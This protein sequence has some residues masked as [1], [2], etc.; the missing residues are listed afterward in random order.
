MNV[1][2]YAAA[3]GGTWPP[4]SQP[5]STTFALSWTNTHEPCIT[6]VASCSPRQSGDWHQPTTTHARCT[7]S[8][9]AIFYANFSLFGRSNLKQ[10]MSTKLIIKM[11]L[12]NNR[13]GDF[14]KRIKSQQSDPA[15]K[16][17]VRCE[18]Q[19]SPPA[20]PGFNNS[21]EDTIGFLIFT[22]DAANQG[23][24]FVLQ[25][26]SYWIVRTFPISKTEYPWEIF[27]PAS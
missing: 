16:I 27:I 20:L 12:H 10:W 21:S 6:I 15:K 19:F 25:V 7:Q 3:A 9:F 13:V 5:G 17:P 4:S 11:E 1:C 22:R 2:T 24:L 26:Y 14:R 8:V 23:M 18:I